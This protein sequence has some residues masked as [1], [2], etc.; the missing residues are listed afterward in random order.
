MALSN[1]SAVSVVEDHE[2]RVSG[3]MPQTGQLTVSSQIQAMA[4]LM[5]KRIATARAF[6]R[7][8]TQ[9]KRE[10]TSLLTEDVET[11]RAAE[12]AKP[13]GGG[14]VT[15][16]SVRLA[17]IAA[18][19]WGNLEVELADPVV[20]DKSVTVTAYAYDLEKNSRQPGIAS[21]SI[22]KKDGSRY[23]QHMVDT[24]VNATASK[25]RRNAILAIIPRAFVND[26]LATAK[27]VAEGSQE[28]FESRR[29][30]TLDYFATALKVKP[31]QV[32]EFLGIQGEA[33]LTEDHLS[34]LRP[35]A[36]AIKDGE[37]KAEEFFPTSGESKLDAV[38][39][40]VAER[41]AAASGPAPPAPT[42]TQQTE[43]LATA[44]VETAPLAADRPP[45]TAA[46]TSP[47]DGQRQFREL[48]NKY[49]EAGGDEQAWLFA[50][51]YRDADQA[52]TASKATL[53]KLISALAKDVDALKA[54]SGG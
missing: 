16:P 21:T 1:G 28:P 6:P 12:Y 13:V 46:N 49:V 18:L 36:T 9:F 25:A 31:E 40:K 30:K 24:M 52:L 10:A 39:A 54:A 19:C 34:E 47:S 14:T 43:R 38:R 23:P 44:H 32:F 7:S 3:F 37:A 17:E 42:P 15:G 22:L 51:N 41:K 4:V 33:D 29:R 20:G 8:I 2:T 53:S 26:L 48:L 45:L 50:K 11:A 27:R 5:D 35:V